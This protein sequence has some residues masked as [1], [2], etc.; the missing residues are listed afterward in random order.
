MAEQ[1][2]TQPQRF[3]E[4]DA[5]EI[6]RDATE[7]SL[8]ARKAELTREDLV[9]MAK[10][11][12]LDEASVEAALELRKKRA[13]RARFRRNMSLGLVSHVGS[14]AAVIGGLFLLDLAGGPGWWVQWPAIGWGIGL[15][16]HV[17]GT[18]IAMIKGEDP[19]PGVQTSARTPQP[20]G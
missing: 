3:S 13:A 17:M 12:G 5:A 4:D 20:R 15:A 19:T 16:T 9:S 1:T 8:G 2:R 11:L 7:L 10:E 14:Y 18:A 6:I